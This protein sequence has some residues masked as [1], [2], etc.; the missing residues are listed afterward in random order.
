MWGEKHVLNFPYVCCVVANATCLTSSD[1][2]PQNSSW[3]GARCTPVVNRSFEHHTGDS[4]IWLV[5]TPIL[6]ENTLGLPPL[7]PCR[8]PH[9]RTCGSTAV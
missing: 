9:V 6:R 1:R 2:S 4:T 8:Q 3:Q 5:S 7:I